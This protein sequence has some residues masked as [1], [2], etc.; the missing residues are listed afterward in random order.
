MFFVTWEDVRVDALKVLLGNVDNEAV[1]K[2]S[3]SLG[4][5]PTQIRSLLNQMK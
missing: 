4:V 5:P 1:E 2:V 3:E